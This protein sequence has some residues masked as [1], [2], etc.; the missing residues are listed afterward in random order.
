MTPQGGQWTPHHFP[1]EPQHRLGGGPT[2][3]QGT[4]AAAESFVQFSRSVESDSLR[5]HGLLHARPPCPSPTPE[6]TQTH[7]H[8]VGDGTQPSHPLSSPSPPAFHLSQHRVFANGSSHQVAKVLELSFSVNPSN[9]HS[10]LISFRMDWLKPQ[11][12][13][14]LQYQRQDGKSPS[15]H[16]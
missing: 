8:R 14:Y 2:S 4:R 12:P 15:V 3:Q 10:G 13:L 9:E 1:P 6:I 7:V 16:P 5:P 11:P